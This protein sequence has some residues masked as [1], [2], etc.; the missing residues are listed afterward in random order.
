MGN[1]K[2]K[3][4]PF[5]TKRSI[6]NASGKVI[7][8]KSTLNSDGKEYNW[9]TKREL[10]SVIRAGIPYDSIEVISKRLNN[11]I[12]SV[13]AIMGIPQTTY[14][15]K[16]SEHLLLDSRN[17]ELVILINE[18]IDYG[19]EVFNNEEEKFQRW[20]KKPNL[21]IGGNTPESMLDTITGINEVKFTLNRIEFGNLA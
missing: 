14:N 12:K 4:Q 11:P 13:L 20:L 3:T 16:K 7:K 21:S 15:K 17:S 10:V 1:I 8:I 18:L 9:S 6:Q 5:N 2:S 19:I